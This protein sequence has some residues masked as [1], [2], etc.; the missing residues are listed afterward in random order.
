MSYLDMQAHSQ[1]SPQQQWGIPPIG[2]L[3]G[4]PGMNGLGQ[5]A[6]G[7]FG[8]QMGAQ[9]FG[10]Q[11]PGAGQAGWGQP[12]RQLSQQDVSE[13]VRQLVP[14]LPQ[15]IA[16]AQ[17]PQAAYGQHNP[18][19]Q[20]ARTLTPQDVNEVVRQILPIL[21]QIVGMLQGQTA[22]QPMAPFGGLGTQP[23][24]GQAAFGAPSPSANWQG[25]NFGQQAPHLAAF[26]GQQASG[27]QQQR[28][29]SQQDI[30]EV[31]RQL[32]GLIPQVVNHLQATQQRAM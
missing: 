32:A 20:Q 30:T 6:Y 31:A 27:G 11:N 4:V 16:Q 14:L 17:Q 28:Q 5:A 21:P 24:W 22:N 2:Q 23:P 18:F 15:L 8:G 25:Q 29:L 19:G 13:V 10:Q 9:G 7:Q 1:Q 3:L 12:Q 26:G